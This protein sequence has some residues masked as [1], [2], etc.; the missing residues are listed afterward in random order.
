MSRLFSILPPI[1]VALRPWALAL[2]LLPA[3]SACDRQDANTFSQS[4]VWDIARI[5]TT[6]YAPD[7]TVQL[8]TTATDVG[9][10]AFIPT[11]G[12]PATETEFGSTYPEA[13]FY[14]DKAVPLEF[15]NPILSDL[16][17]E[18]FVDKHERRRVSVGVNGVV[19]TATSVTYTIV[20][21]SADRQEWELVRPYA[22]NVIQRRE[23]WQV[24][25]TE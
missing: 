24:R 10:V 18:W 21:E 23:V 8:V 12:R 25:R 15:F 11:D 7:G 9:Q 5:T 2:A 14:L 16:P 1:A 17:L 13:R 22:N 3:V 4:G 20:S 19:N 6:D